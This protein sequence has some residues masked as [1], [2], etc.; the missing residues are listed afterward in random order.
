MAEPLLISG[1]RQVVVKLAVATLFAGYVQTL[2]TPMMLA[3]TDV[4]TLGTIQSGSALG[5][6]AGSILIS[7]RGLGPKL[8][9]QMSLGLGSGGLF[10]SA[11][12]IS[13][14]PA[15]IAV[16]LFLFF[17]L[18]ASHQHKRRSSDQIRNSQS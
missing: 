3:I 4:K 1:V 7:L 2:F 13:T 10:L 17:F 8:P 15:L 12:G 16:L 6:L 11:M 5:M 14:N 18:S 9:L